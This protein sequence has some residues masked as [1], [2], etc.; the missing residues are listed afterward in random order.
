M[1]AETDVQQ[2]LLLAAGVCPAAVAPL[3]EAGATLLQVDDEGR[4]ILHVAAF[5]QQPVVVDL[6]ASQL[7][8][9]PTGTTPT[10]PVTS[11]AP[12]PSPCLS[13]AVLEATCDRSR[14]PLLAALSFLPGSSDPTGRAASSQRV[15]AVVRRL[16]QLGADP[17]ARAAASSAGR[18]RAGR[19]LIV[20]M[21]YCVNPAAVE[22]LLEAGGGSASET[23][24]A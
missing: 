9:A 16:L 21:E 24:A 17:E 19:P 18:A 4:S 2:P 3:L 6:I 11:V 12:G 20:A 8:R 1:Q 7:L 13:A 15:A 10:D 22:A 23:D 5:R 14:T